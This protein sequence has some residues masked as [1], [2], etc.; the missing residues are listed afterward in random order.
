MSHR[1]RTIRQFMW[2]D[3]QSIIENITA[4]AQTNRDTMRENCTIDWSLLVDLERFFK[5]M[6]EGV[7][8]IYHEKMAAFLIIECNAKQPFHFLVY[9]MHEQ[10]I[11]I[12]D[13]SMRDVEVGCESDLSPVYPS[14]SARPS[15]HR[16]DEYLSVKVKPVFLVNLFTSRV[17]VATQ[18]GI[19]QYASDALE[20]SPI[21][22][23]DLLNDLE[24]QLQLPLEG[25]EILPELKL[26]S[27]EVRQHLSKTLKKSLH[28]FDDLNE[29]PLSVAFGLPKLTP[30]H[31]QIV[32][33]LLESGHDPETGQIAKSSS[34]WETLFGECASEKKPL[35]DSTMRSKVDYFPVSSLQWTHKH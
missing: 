9:S 8:P 25:G 34:L 22:A 5:H 11:N 28:Y 20:D 7:N 16:R 29:P 2:K 23:T 33:D 6:L 18:K 35:S 24:S 17:F 19:P 12:D 14:H 13:L 10:E 4:K 27:A 3:K 32:S 31:V 21:P 15:T 1:R 26:I 30:G